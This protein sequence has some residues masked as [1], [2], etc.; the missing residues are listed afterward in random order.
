MPQFHELQSK[1]EIPG[2]FGEVFNPFGYYSFVVDPDR[3]YV[4][5]GEHFLVASTVIS[6]PLMFGAAISGGGASM[7]MWFGMGVPAFYHRAMSAVAFKR[8]LVHGAMRHA[9]QGM[10]G[11]VQRFPGVFAATAVGFGAY[12]ANEFYADVTPFRGIMDLQPRLYS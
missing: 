10:K 8:D 12:L 9:F 6:A 7:P 5:K 11:A 4:E 3:D 1:S 2:Y